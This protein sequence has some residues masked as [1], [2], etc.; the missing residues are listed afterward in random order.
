MI[1]RREFLG[2]MAATATVG[3]VPGFMAAEEKSEAFVDEWIPETDLVKRADY[4]A[5]M[6]AGDNPKK[7]VSIDRLEQAFD[8]VR[9]EIDETSVTNVP[10]VWMVYNMGVVVKTKEAL[11]SIDLCHRRASELVP[12]LD[13]ALITHNHGDHYTK[14]FYDEMDGARK[15]VVNNFIDNY[16]GSRWR[17]D[18][19]GWDP[20]G[21]RGAA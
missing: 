2:C 11:F 21:G 8:R 9:K 3:A 1:D 4:L 20:G 18:I 5:Y 6:K 10:S 14:D 12:K 16:G 15:I 17:S 19:R 13:F 7:L